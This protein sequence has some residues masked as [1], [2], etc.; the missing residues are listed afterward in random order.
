MR[1]SNKKKVLIYTTNDSIFTLPIIFKICRYLNDKKI[2][3]YL[4]GPN[5]IRGIKVLIIFFLFGSLFKFPKLLKKGIKIGKI[6]TLS[7]V[8]LV[9]KI[10][11]NYQYGLSF[12]FPKKILLQKFNI[13][14]F[15]CGNFIN[16]RGSFIFFY[17]FLYN[18]KKLDLTFHQIN[19][20]FDSGYIINKKKVIISNHDAI[21]IC[22]MYS[23][24]FN[25][26]K[27]SLN[28]IKKNYKVKPIIGKINKE[29]NYFLI[30][31]TFLYNFFKKMH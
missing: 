28:K 2:D 3:I 13:Y 18:W 22:K 5:K 16:Q 24:D 9:K 21:D 10:N 30:I 14:N 26:I 1:L 17:K 19:S 27:D 29:P 11:N 20:N 4:S 31:K 6:L 8:K 15:H 12:N 25:F 23:N 7:N